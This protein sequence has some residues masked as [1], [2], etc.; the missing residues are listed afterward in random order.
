M[1]VALAK[2]GYSVGLIDTGLDLFAQEMSLREYESKIIAHYLDKNNNNVVLVAKKLDIG[3][4]KIYNMIKG[5][6]L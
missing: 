6:E 3:K 2:L 5:G 1:A 4:S